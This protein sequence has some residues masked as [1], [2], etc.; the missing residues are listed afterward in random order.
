MHTDLI[1]GKQ[2]E[3]DDASLAA[4]STHS[5][6]SLPRAILIRHVKKWRYMFRFQDQMVPREREVSASV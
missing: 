3:F 6:H 5:D 1:E 2:L 4:T